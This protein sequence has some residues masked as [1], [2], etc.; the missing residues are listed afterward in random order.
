G[1]GRRSAER[2]SVTRR[3]LV[4]GSPG[5]RA[6]GNAS[7][8]STCGDFFDPGTVLPARGE[9]FAMIP[10]AF[11]LSLQPRPAIEGSA[12]SLGTDGYPRPPRVHACE[13]WPRAP[14]RPARVTPHRP[15][16]PL[17]PFRIGS[18]RVPS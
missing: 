14:P 4:P 7:R 8:R 16:L 5:N 13:A 17:P 12:P 11:A 6:H 15:A 1:E 9:A 3:G 18:I 10:K 2:R